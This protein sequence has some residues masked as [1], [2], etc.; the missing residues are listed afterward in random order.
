MSNDTK[1]LHLDKQLRENPT[2]QLFVQL[3]DKI[4]RDKPPTA[5]ELFMY[6]SY[7]QVRQYVRDFKPPYK[8]DEQQAE[9]E[10][11]Y[12]NRYREHLW[13]KDLYMDELGTI[14]CR[15][16]LAIGSCSDGACVWENSPLKNTYHPYDHDRYINRV[17]LGYTLTE[18]TA[19]AV[20]AHFEA[21]ANS[22]GYA[23]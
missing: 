5:Y 17:H 8:S 3:T 11:Q 18:R 4:K 19:I 16:A 23:F 13:S 20:I 12:K 6:L 14:L 7:S 10:A 15:E 9:A 2:K 22:N 1:L 21:I